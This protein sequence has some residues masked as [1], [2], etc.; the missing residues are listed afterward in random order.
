MHPQRRIANEVSMKRINGKIVNRRLSNIG[1]NRDDFRT[2]PRARNDAAPDADFFG[3][4]EATSLDI[5]R[6]L[7]GRFQNRAVVEAQFTRPD[8]G[9]HADVGDFLRSNLAGFLVFRQNRVA[10]FD[11]LDGLGRATSSCILNLIL[12]TVFT[13]S[14]SRNVQEVEMLL[15][16][17]MPTNSNNYSF[18]SFAHYMRA[19][20]EFRGRNLTQVVR[21]NSKFPFT[22]INDHIIAKLLKYV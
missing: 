1:L 19:E 12:Q 17:E 3:F 11:L 15:I 9:A 22:S 6:M 5:Q 16:F 13:L 10:E 21:Q 20:R 18:F 8:V 2:R 14:F 7:V 4:N